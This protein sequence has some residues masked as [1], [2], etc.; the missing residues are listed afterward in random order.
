MKEMSEGDQM[1][2]TKKVQIVEEKHKQAGVHATPMDRIWDWDYVTER[3]HCS[4]D[5]GHV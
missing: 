2:A 3:Q 4:A 5:R 1:K